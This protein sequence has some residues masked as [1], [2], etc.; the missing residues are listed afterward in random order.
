MKLSWM[1]SAMLLSVASCDGCTERAPNVCCTSDAECARLGLPSGSVSD[2][3]CGQ[4]HVCRDF[5]CVPDEGPDASAPDA[6]PDAPTGRCNPNAP[7][8]PPTRLAN[9]NTQFEDL[10]MA[11]TYDQLKAY[12]VRSSGIGGY[13]L[14]SASRSSAESDFPA[15]TSDSALAAVTAAPGN[16]LYLYPTSDDL[17]VYYRR[18]QTWV[19]SYRLDSNEPF[20]AGT[21]LYV[22]GTQL[23]AG[24]VMISADS[25]TLYYSNASSQL[26]AAS[27]G[28][29]NYIFVNSRSVTTF[30]LTDFAI[31]ADELTLYYSDYPN[32]DIFRTTRSSKAL[33]F[34]VGIPVENV[35][36]TGPDIP[37]Y[38]SPDD[39]FLYFRATSSSSTQDNDVWVARR[40]R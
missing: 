38:V 12:F 32:A 7:F 18:E 27:H 15:P 6:T 37:L 16:E 33:P 35:N 21:E 14:V 28:G 36:T 1:V 9:V 10:S 13:F 25:L 19:A 31:S 39:C 5:Y 23:P 30:D 8:D 4:G 11:M 34:G 22:N 2:Y 3:S 20:G 26:R 40:G 17:V 24:R 29:V